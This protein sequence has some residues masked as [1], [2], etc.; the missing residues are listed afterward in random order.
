LKN[1]VESQAKTKQMKRRENNSETHAVIVL[2]VR[3]KE[4]NLVTKGLIP[5]YYR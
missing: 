1:Y 2:I 5:R 3:L 4:E